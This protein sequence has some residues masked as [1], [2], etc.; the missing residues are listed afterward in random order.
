MAKIKISVCIPA[1]NRSDLLPELLDSIFFQDFR[2]FEV[3]IAEDKSPERE[4]IAT[5]ISGYVKRYPHQLVYS[6]NKENL[7]YD[8]NLRRLIE[9][10]HGDYVLFMGNDDLMASGA[11]S[12]VS[13]VIRMYP[14]VGVVLRSYASFKI[15]PD[16]L[17][18]TFRYFN[19]D[20][21]FPAGRATIT[22]FFRRSVFISG[23]VLR[24]QSALAL[25]T[26]QFDGTLLYQ[27]YL[28]GKI[29]ARENGVYVTKIL[30]YQRLDGIPDFG[31]SIAE[32]ELFV[33]HEQTVESSVHFMRGML[34]IAKAVEQAT[35]LLVYKP[36]L[37][38]IGNYAYPILSIQAQ[39]SRSV[40]F[41]YFYALAKLGLWRIPLFHVYA[42]GLLV[43]GRSSCDWLIGMV[44][45]FLGRAPKI[46]RIYSGRQ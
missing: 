20:A 40:F 22:T 41:V 2:D 5:V 37:Y 24:R 10:A 23:M 35:G 25:S 12:V 42:L 11:L 21:F 18:Q 28:V 36:I 13:D 30:S 44:K 45:R 17:V 14:Q 7:G 38:D 16:D 29:L 34:T 31:N 6:E 43:F 39:R 33:P 15:S 8:G 1:Y 3:V 32:K 26:D 46:G 27:Q 9:L 19:N 4:A